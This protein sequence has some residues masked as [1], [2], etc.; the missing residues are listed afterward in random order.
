[1]FVSRGSSGAPTVN[2]NVLGFPTLGGRRDPRHKNTC[3]SVLAKEM[4]AV[5]EHKLRRTE[6]Q[7]IGVPGKLPKNE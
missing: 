5:T 1:M 7:D 6:M 2:Y 3:I 4:R